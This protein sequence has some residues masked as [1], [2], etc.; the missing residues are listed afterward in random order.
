M[1]RFRC[2][3]A[4]VLLAT[5]L[6]AAEPVKPPTPPSAPKLGVTV[7][8]ARYDGKLSDNEA[9]FT[10]DLDLLAAGKGDATVSLFEGDVAVLTT[11]LPENLQLVRRGTQYGLL[12][13]KE[14]AYKFKLELLAKITR[15]EPWNQ[16]TFTGP[17]AVIASIGAQ[18]TGEGVE[19][20]LLKGTVSDSGAARVTGILGADQ[21]VALRWQSKATEIA[22]KALLTCDST[23]TAQIT[24][25]VVKYNTALRYEIV[26]GSVSRLQVSLPPNQALTK[27]QG[28]NIRDWQV[29]DQ[30]LVVEFVRPVEKS[31]ALTLLSEQTIESA[32]ATVRLAPPQPLDVEREAGALAVSAEDVVVETEKAEGLRQVNATGGALAAYQF[33]ARPVALSL[34]LRRIEPVLNVADRV[35]VRL[36]ESRLSVTHALSLSVEKAGVYTLELAYPAGFVV[37][38]V[39]GDAAGGIEDWKATGGKLALTFANRVLGRRALEVQLEQALKSVPEKILVAPLRVTGAAKE[40]TVIG[41]ASAAGIQLKTVADGLAGLR[42]VAINLLPNRSDESLAFNAEQADW[43]LTLAAERLAARITA[44]IFNLVT[45]GDGV[46]GGSATIRYAIL[47]QGVQEFRVKLPTLWKNIDFTGSNIRRKEQQ[48]NVWAIGLQEKAWGGYTLVVTYDMPFDLHKA[49]L[50]VGGIHCDGVERESGTV[51]VTSA[52]NLQIAEG[53]KSAGD[54][55]QSSGNVPATTNATAVAETTATVRRVDESEL[56][57]HDRALITRPVLLAYQYTGSAYEI[58]TEVTRFDELPVLEAVA[59]RTQ[60]TTVVTEDGQTLTQ[61]SFLVKNND[62]QFQSF[63]LPTG[64]EF[65]SCY[66]RGQATKPERSGNKLLVP[67]PRGVNRD[68]A[69][70]VD[71]VYKKSVGSLKSL[72]PSALSLSAPV[73]DMQ[74]TYAEWEVFV[75]QTSRLAN[76]GGN[77]IV[78]RGTTY[79]LRDAWREL[80][81]FYDRFVREYFGSMLVFAA[82]FVMAFLVAV[83]FRR[84]WRGALTVVAVLAVFVLLAGMLLPLTCATRR[85]AS[86][87]RQLAYAET[88]SEE[89]EGE[90]G[91]RT[92]AKLSDHE[93][94]KMEELKVTTGKPSFVG[95][96]VPVKAPNLERQ[97]G[98]GDLRSRRSESGA[99]ALG[100]TTVPGHGGGGGDGWNDNGRQLGLDAG[101]TTLSVGG[102]VAAAT[103]NFAAKTVAGLRP[104]R[105]EIPKT[106]TRFVFTKVLNVRSEPLSVSA[107]ALD[108][109][110]F[111]IARG[112]AQA[113]VFVVGLALLWW[114]WRA[115]RRRSFAVALGL[116]LAFGGV[117]ALLLSARLLDAALILL[118]PL[119]GLVALGWLTRKAWRAIPAKAKAAATPPPVPPVVVA[120]LALALTGWI[121]QAQGQEVRAT[122][123]IVSAT[124]T[125]VVR[126]AK[127]ATEGRGTAL[128]DAVLELNAS[129]TNQTVRLFGDDVAVEE[130][131]G[132]KGE[133]RRGWFSFSR[134][135]TTDAQLVRDGKSVGVLLP[136]KGTATIRLKFLV[137]LGGDVT[138]R[139]LGFAIPPA[140]VSRLVATL[141]EPQAMVEL[142]TAVSFATKPDGQKTR[143]EA[144]IGS[145]ERVELSWTPRTKRAAEIAAT[146]FCQNASLVT[147][148]SGVMNVRSVLDYQVT[149]GELR[150]MRVRVPAGQRLMRVEGEQ[151]RTWK[152]DSENGVSVATVELLKG[153]SPSYRLTVETEKPLVGAEAASVKVEVPHA[154]D[155]KRETGVLALKA[156]DELSVS[157]ATASELQKVDVE[158]FARLGDAKAAAGVGTAYRFLKPEFELKARIEAMQ[159][160]IEAVVRNL[161]RVST[162]QLS[163]HATVEYTIKRAGV[164]TLRLALPPEFRVERVTGQNV[165]Q[166]V[167]KAPT[168]AGEPR[169]LEVTLKQR[170]MGAYTLQVNLRRTLAAL[171]KQLEITGVQPLDAQ[172]LTGLVSVGSEEGVQVRSEAFDGLTEVPSA[173]VADWVGRTGN[174]LA[175]KLIPGETNTAAGWKLTATTERID[176]WV[177]AEVM[178]WVSV[179]ETLLSGRSLVRYEIQNAPT[180]EF[181][182]KVPAAWRNV[183]VNGANIRRKDRDAA[184]GEWR[185]ELQNKVRGTFTLTVTWERPWNIADG[186]LELPGVEAVGVE[187]ETGTIAV[188][189]Q[190]PLKIEPKE[191]SVE[192]LKID[193]RELPDWAEAAGQT[194]TL[195]FRYL[196]PGY[197]LTLGAQRFEEAEVLQALVDNVN[198]TT[199]VSEDGQMM[200]EMSLAIRNN[201]RQY[202]EVTLP[203]NA[204][205]V[206]S[207]FVAGQP[208]RP[209][210]RGGK[211]LLP[212]ERSGADGAPIAVELTYIG[213]D[214]FPRT[215]GEVKLES[216]ALDVPFKNARW[217]LY[218]PPDYNYSGFDGTMRRELQAAAVVAASPV[219]E[220]FS[221]GDYTVAEQRNKDMR[222]QDLQLSI[223]NVKA[224]LKSGKLNEAAKNWNRYNANPNSLTVDDTRANDEIVQLKKQVRKQ[225]GQQL[226]QAQQTFAYGNNANAYSGNTVVNSGALTVNGR[227]V[228]NGANTYNGGTTI[229]GSFQRNA[230]GAVVLNSDGAQ[231]QQPPVAQGGQVIDNNGIVMQFDAETAEQQ[232]EKVAKAQEITVTK[233]LPL[234]VNLPKRGIHLSFTQ[235]LQTDI[236]KPMALQFHAA[237]SKGLGLTATVGL[238]VAGF[239]GLWWLVSL[240]VSRRPKA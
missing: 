232:V 207:A 81:R 64:A 40:T 115:A 98:D 34:K 186:A 25:T 92:D 95:T 68:E 217:D 101:Y 56:A 62:K 10:V 55:A 123:A 83:A 51:A 145:G 214:T 141:E 162:E 228:L 74:T 9:R 152:L 147:F 12:V 182:L 154:A 229:N 223:S 31:Y 118:A 14:G 63:T 58:V 112:T 17:A 168:K 177:R 173:M 133:T 159:P 44:D 238:T 120:L 132:P 138:K 225:Q 171:P 20:Q 221:L 11:K 36:E 103:D 104:I 183:E 193:R 226:L 204:T 88:T 73:T 158:E 170:T 4:F 178:N 166:H 163:L 26:Q 150:Q 7:R 131:T 105:I 87:S 185:V 219:V 91:G 143:V 33:H 128:F 187:R 199:V 21:V 129:E 113:L 189:A 148:G 53:K 197:K 137:K 27:L 146:V 32:A 28:D 172:K 108:N 180:K 157:A 184:S 236:R 38:D 86:R 121:G 109:E 222:D 3:F 230:S 130:F 13:T 16:I 188:L 227:L 240:I 124:Y 117:G 114:Q 175:F 195:A 19:V 211:L 66:V 15:A 47:N 67:L 79:D 176:S 61:A 37:A 144:V 201:A 218:L 8:Q 70:A 111:K 235:T 151:I 78:A 97:A 85:A 42:E 76:F 71:I 169:V 161:V 203:A 200:T 210:V 239:L 93:G 29:K 194:P 57:E 116:A 237:E 69:F 181:R 196:R 18:A 198:L 160:Q 45:V 41:A 234:R 190:P 192:L 100:R 23:A 46:V 216:P 94:K 107:T 119:C 136:A 84:G 205:N 220:M 212:L 224:Q 206:W 75:P 231:A 208:V 102:G 179:T 213:G 22:R 153:V 106:G 89:I 167:E 54:T 24:P 233:A 140:L 49:A 135:E 125:G 48:G 127:G 90:K 6:F 5:N 215:R 59:D 50:P 82:L 52:A 60:L 126:E 165:A 96:P 142:P 1:R 39:R 164:F 149:Q 174:A 80:I 2:L 99:I 156:S 110:A 139:Q 122:T 30:T 134:A 77:M 65:W 209:S 191:S 43:K 155:V 35:T 202:L 72:W